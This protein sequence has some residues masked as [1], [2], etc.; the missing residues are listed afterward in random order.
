M[1][2]GLRLGGRVEEVFEKSRKDASGRRVGIFLE[3]VDISHDGKGLPRSGL[4]V[5]KDATV[6]ALDRG[7]ST[8]R[9]AET[10]SA[11]IML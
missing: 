1:V 3:F 5:G 4:S 2:G 7:G 9:L 6:E 10:A 8:S 11:P